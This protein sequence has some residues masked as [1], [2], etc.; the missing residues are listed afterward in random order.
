[1]NCA[2]ARKRIFQKIDNEI[3]ISDASMLDVH[4]GSCESCTREFRM[5]AMPLRIGQ[6]IPTL[7]ASPFFYSRLKARIALEAQGMTIWQ[8]ISGLSRRMVPALAA[9]TLTFISLFGYV[10][11][12]QM[13]ND[14]AQAYE[15]MITAGDLHYRTVAVEE[16]DSTIRRV[17]LAFEDHDPDQYPST[18]TTSGTK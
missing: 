15:R 17:L 9:I 10:H 12:L 5:L 1:M 3:S 11:Y 4:L 16:T 7:E 2:E 14:A 6:M 13:R 18:E 8:I